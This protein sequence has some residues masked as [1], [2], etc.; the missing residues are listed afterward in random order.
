M[1][2][3]GKKDRSIPREV[4]D[5]PKFQRL[6][7]TVTRIARENCP[8]APSNSA[9]VK[10]WFGDLRKRDVAISHGTLTDVGWSLVQE[11]RGLDN[12]R[13]ATYLDK[14]PSSWNSARSTARSKFAEIGIP[15]D[16]L[17]A[18][19]RGKGQRGDVL[20]GLTDFLNDIDL[21]ETADETADDDE[22]AAET[23]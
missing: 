19:N 6:M 9:A 16:L 21:D 4:L 22:T 10:E 18:S 12:E 5:S 1:A 2:K 8:N 3:N 20:E 15:D 14:K 17:P 7:K 11:E 23:V 13:M